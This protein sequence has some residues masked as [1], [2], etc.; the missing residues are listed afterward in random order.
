MSRY[1]LC[2]SIHPLVCYIRYTVMS[3]RF[4]LTILFHSRIPVQI[5]GIRYFFHWIF[6]RRDWRICC[7]RWWSYLFI[8]IPC[9]F[10]ISFCCCNCCLIFNLDICLCF[11]VILYKMS[12]FSKRFNRYFLRINVRLYNHLYG[13]SCIISIEIFVI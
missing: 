3:S 10:I 4:F 2:Q 1:L 5:I 8:Y 7:S 6:D 9:S 13:R 12:M 11:L